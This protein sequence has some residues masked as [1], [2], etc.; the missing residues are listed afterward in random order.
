MIYLCVDDTDNLKSRGTGRLARAIA[1]KLSKKYSVFGVT[2]HQLYVHLDIPFTSHNSCAVIHI[3]TDIKECTDEIFE[4]A[5]KEIYDDFIEGSD[6][7]LSVAHESQILPS[8]VAYGKDAKDTVLTQENARTLAK[9]L[10]IRLEGLGGTEDGVIGSMAGLGLAFTGND[11]RYLQIGHIRELLGPQP[12]EKLMAAGIDAIFTLDGQLVTAGM[13]FNDANK[14]VKPCPLNG[15]SILFV[16]N[17][18][19]IISAVKRN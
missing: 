6:P 18:D 7:G 1:A 4:I 5:K 13:I 14:S 2:R 17:N 16:D 8:L 3:D 12:V 19:G 10:N 15:K 9:N 11:G